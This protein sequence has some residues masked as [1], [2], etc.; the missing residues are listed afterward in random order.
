MTIEQFAQ[1][2]ICIFGGIAI[3]LVGRKEGEWRRWG[4]IAGFIS[5]PAWLYTTLKNHQWG[6]FSMAIWYTYSWLQGI[7]NHWKIEE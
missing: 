5:Q 3:W 2:W 7:V 4:Y 1:A 6:I